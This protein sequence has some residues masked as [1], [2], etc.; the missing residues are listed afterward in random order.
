MS[1][2]PVVSVVL[3]VF[4]AE[5]YVGAAVES[6]LDQTHRDL[7]LIVVDDGSVDGSGQILREY[8]AADPRVRVHRQE[9]QGQG[10]ALNEGFR[11]AAG[12]YVAVM[13][14]DDVAFPDRLERQVAL[15]EENPGVLLVGGAVVVTNAEGAPIETVRF[16]CSD[17]EL[18]RLLPLR[19]VFSH[20]TVVMRRSAFAA[21]GGYRPVV[22]P[23]EDYDLW[24]R[25]AEMGEMRN[26]AATVLAYRVHDAQL[27][28][29]EQ[30]EMAVA[31]LA[32]Q[33]AARMRTG[34]GEDPLWR[35]PR[36]DAAALVGLGIDPEAVEAAV[37]VRRSRWADRVVTG[38]DAPAAGPTT[39]GAAAGDGGTGLT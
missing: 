24:L 32:I 23:A 25:M 34:G 10:T 21:A 33:A 13:D 30:R 31:G 9:N 12:T 22:R 26:V 28:Q 15:L 17:A 39:A 8:E 16:P 14:A 18:R 36:L 4:N 19:N 2:P 35:L 29:V 11:R 20:P 38:R 1:P 5:A 7:E 6:I 3:P 37:E 27:S